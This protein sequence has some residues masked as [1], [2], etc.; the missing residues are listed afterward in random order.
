MRPDVVTIG[1]TMAALRLDGAASLS[2]V[3]SLSVAGSEGN[4]AVGLARLGHRVRWVSAVGDDALGRLVMRAYAAEGVD[5]S[6]VRIDPAAPTGILVSEQRLPGIARV[7]YHRSGSAGSSLT[8][9]DATSALKDLPRIVHVTGITPALSQ[10][11]A[12]A[13]QTAVSEARRAGARVSLDVNYRS[14]LWAPAAARA[15]LV[16]LL[17]DVDVLIADPEELSVLV[18]E[19]D[20]VSR[21]AQ[22]HEAGPSE[23]V[24][25]RGAEGASASLEGEQVNRP[26]RRVTAVDSIGA[27]DAFVAGYLSAT[28]DGL[29]LGARLERANVAGAFAVSSTGDWEGLPR[30]A[31]LGLLDQADGDVLR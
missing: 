6:A 16:P 13:V 28:L 5:T 19:G 27:G 1:E 31:E 2:P 20:E 24:I 7:D 11:A 29:D 23:V 12:A 10:E 4:V 15:A 30:R 8:T 22:L 21:V 3:A 17:S 9:A 26:A 18:P 14:R 25:K